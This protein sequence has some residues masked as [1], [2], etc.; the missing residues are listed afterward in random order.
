[1]LIGLKTLHEI[2]DRQT[3]SKDTEAELKIFIEKIIKKTVK[4]IIKKLP[5]LLPAG[6]ELNF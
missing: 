4:K 5:K 1:V 3:R 2:D 6:F